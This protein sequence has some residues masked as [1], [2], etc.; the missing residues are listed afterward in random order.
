[1]Q[2]LLAKVIVGL[3]FLL[4]VALAATKDASAISGS[5][6]FN[7]NSRDDTKW[8]EVTAGTG[9]MIDETNQRLEITLP[10]NS[11]NYPQSD[12]FGAWYLGRCALEGNFDIQVDYQLLTWPSDSGVRVGLIIHPKHTVERTGL[13]PTEVWSPPPPSREV[14][15]TNYNDVLTPVGTTDTSGKLRQT[16]TGS[17]LRGYYYSGGAW[18]EIASASIGQG[19]L[20]YVLSSWS[21]DSRFGDSLTQVAFD[22]FIVNSG[23][24]NCA[25]GGIADFPRV[26]EPAPGSVEASGG[27][28]PPYGALAG[29]LTA[30]VIAMA[31]GWYTVRRHAQSQ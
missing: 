4:A 26:E 15:L 3:L 9:P 30:S 12:E 27:S 20:R 24:L 25:V 18:V 16:R 2:P 1:M 13:G 17:T 10:A 23:E 21:G 8:A 14:Y 29:V 5:D 7:D 6:D 28:S 31:A 19:G 22:N 11:V